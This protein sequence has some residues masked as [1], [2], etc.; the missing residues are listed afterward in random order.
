MA[1]RSRWAGEEKQ[2][3]SEGER[4][5]NSYS[6]S[7]ETTDNAGAAGGATGNFTAVIIRLRKTDGW[8][9]DKPEFEETLPVCWKDPILFVISARPRR[10]IIRSYV[11]CSPSTVK[12]SACRHSARNWNVS[13]GN[14][15]GGTLRYPDLSGNDNNHH[16]FSPCRDIKHNKL[17]T[18]RL[19]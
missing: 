11:W 8:R 12:Q 13:M 2:N 16:S 18:P 4:T 14:R 7:A 1:C 6:G 19:R 10:L 5:N 9:D 17:F 3:D 15:R